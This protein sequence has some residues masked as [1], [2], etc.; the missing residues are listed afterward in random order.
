MKTKI[1]IL[2]LL[3]IF[4]LLSTS[5]FSQQAVVDFLKGGVNDAEKL[6]EGYLEPLGFGLG[7]A[8]NGG[9][10]NTAK[11]HKTLGFNVTLTASAAL[12]PS[13]FQQFDLSDIGFEKLQL[14]DPNIYL[15]PTIASQQ[16]QRPMLHYSETFPPMTDP[17]TILEFSSPNG[18]RL[19]A[20]PLP[21][22]R[23][24]VGLPMGFE[25]TARYMP[26]YD[27]RGRRFTLWGAGLKYDLLQ[28]IPVANKLPFLNLSVMGAYSQ[29]GFGMELDFQSDVYPQSVNGIPVSGGRPD[30][31]NQELDLRVSGYTINL[32]ASADLPVITAYAAFGYTASNT[33]L[34]LLGDYP[35][36]NFDNQ[37][38]TLSIQDV[39]DPVELDF[40]SPGGPQFTIGAKLKLAVIHLH[41]DYTIAEFPVA[42]AGIGISMR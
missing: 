17:V 40:T 31:D 32:I 28:I 6:A 21:M 26:V 5:V 14:R 24:G 38:A 13:Q 10:F 41:A 30:Y 33:T 3:L 22:V 12:I 29:L 7:S 37:Q 19:P 18:V 2:S 27:F 34:R 39:T 8:L 42:S 20:V 11:V 36:I 4:N 23:A 25:I 15:A 9:W 1:S 35:V 16:D